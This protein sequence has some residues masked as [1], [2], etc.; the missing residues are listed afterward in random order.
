M[1]ETRSLR[2]LLFARQSSLLTDGQQQSGMCL[3]LITDPALVSDGPARQQTATGRLDLPCLGSPARSG[4][5]RASVR[6]DSS[7]ERRGESEGRVAASH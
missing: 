2:S 4:Y 6:D 5:V 1:G 3:R 7:A